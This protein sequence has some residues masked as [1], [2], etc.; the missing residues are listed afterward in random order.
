MQDE[1]ERTRIRHKFVAFTNVVM[2]RPYRVR[3]AEV[4]HGFLAMKAQKMQF[5]IK[6]R[7]FFE[8]IKRI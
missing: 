8:I 7:Q 6:I 5:A 2:D 4:L 3:A 1:R